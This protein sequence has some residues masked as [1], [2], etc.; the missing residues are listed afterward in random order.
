[1]SFSLFF[2]RICCDIERDVFCVPPIGIDFNVVVTT[3][4]G[5]YGGTISI[6]AAICPLWVPIATRID[7]VLIAEW[8]R[9]LLLHVRCPFCSLRHV[10]CEQVWTCCERTNCHSSS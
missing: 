4:C 5:Q 3:H 8:P 9:A 2:G 6:D 1:M 7:I 10:D